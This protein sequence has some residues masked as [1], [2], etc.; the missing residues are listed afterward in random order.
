M[1]SNFCPFPVPVRPHPSVPDPCAQHGWH[2]HPWSHLSR[3]SEDLEFCSVWTQTGKTPPC[4]IYTTHTCRST[5]SPVRIRPH[6]L[7]LL[8]HLDFWIHVLRLLVCIRLKEG[9]VSL[10]AAGGPPPVT[11][12]LG[13]F[14]L[15]QCKA[16]VILLMC[17]GVA[18]L[19]FP[20]PAAPLNSPV[21]FSLLR[22]CRGT[23]YSCFSAASG[24]RSPP[25]RFTCPCTV[26]CCETWADCSLISSDCLRL[27]FER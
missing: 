25:T 26:C 2:Q 6:T 4:S 5:W 7:I 8:F 23:F 21:S 19:L 3:P 9:E 17:S 11:I 24:P 12:P 1:Y 15:E 27:T 16:W 14:G 13:Y 20:D 22:C 10:S 18:A